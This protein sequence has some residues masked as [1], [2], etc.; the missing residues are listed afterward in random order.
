[1]VV[2]IDDKF[3][4]T[5][6]VRPYWCKVY[7]Y[8]D[9]ISS[10]P[11]GW[12]VYRDVDTILTKS[13]V[14]NY[15]TTD[16]AK[17]FVIPDKAGFGRRGGRTSRRIARTSFYLFPNNDQAR[18]L[19]ADWLRREDSD[20]AAVV[21]NLDQGAFNRMWYAGMYKDFIKTVHPNGTVHCGSYLKDDRVRCFE[22]ALPR[23]KN[24]TL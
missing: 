7:A 8:R 20:P 4:E 18:Q 1:M 2:K 3:L 23:Q 16:L 19:T 11:Y 9:L 6:Q 22:K 14:E 5:R 24:K 10:L 15:L 12:I 21:D 13:F 17:R